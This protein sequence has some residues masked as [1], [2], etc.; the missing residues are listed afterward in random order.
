V[1]KSLANTQWWVTLK[2]HDATSA[3]QLGYRASG[4]LNNLDSVTFDSGCEV[5]DEKRDMWT[6]MNATDMPDIRQRIRS[7]VQ[8][9]QVKMKDSDKDSFERLIK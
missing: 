3:R 5:H 6:T 1:E 9:A 8:L 4:R 2:T 7:L